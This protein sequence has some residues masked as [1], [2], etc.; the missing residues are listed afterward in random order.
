MGVS[1]RNESKNEKEWQIRADTKEVENGAFSFYREI[2]DVLS[3]IRG[4]L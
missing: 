3:Y 4:A 1:R 2:T